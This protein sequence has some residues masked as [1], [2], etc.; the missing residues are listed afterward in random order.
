MQRRRRRGTEPASGARARATRAS[1]RRRARGVEVSR[2]EP[3]VDARQRVCRRLFDR[4][5]CLRRREHADDTEAQ[6]RPQGCVGAREQGVNADVDHAVLCTVGRWCV[7]VNNIRR[8]QNNV[9]LI[10]PGQK[11]KRRLSNRP[12][13]VPVPLP[14]PTQLEA[15]R[16]YFYKGRSTPASL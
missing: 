12:S 4:G 16:D 2:P 7:A 11:T 1:V 5:R 3:A 13:S 9:L 15:S 10:D 8:V 6:A 14:T